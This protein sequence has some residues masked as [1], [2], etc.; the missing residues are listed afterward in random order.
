ML[1]VR[2]S[3]QRFPLTR[4]LPGKGYRE[5]NTLYTLRGFSPR[6]EI[7]AHLEKPSTPAA[8]ARAAPMQRSKSDAFAQ[9][10]R[11]RPVDNPVADALPT[12]PYLVFV[13]Y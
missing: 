2:R 11:V 9:A 7:R 1:G 12:S 4:S 13:S 5:C 3:F 6:P 10:G 8:L